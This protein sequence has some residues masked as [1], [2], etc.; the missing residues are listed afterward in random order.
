MT[1]GNSLAKDALGQLFRFPYAGA[2]AFDMNG[3]LARGWPQTASGSAICRYVFDRLA[4][5]ATRSRWLSDGP[6]RSSWVATALPRHPARASPVPLN[7]SRAKL[8]CNF[9]LSARQR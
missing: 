7:R 3:I 1:N 9:L 2:T 8:R 5:H 6:G 4:A